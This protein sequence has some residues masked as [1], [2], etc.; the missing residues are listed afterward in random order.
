MGHLIGDG[1]AVNVTVPAGDYDHGDLYRIDGWSGF[2]I[3]DCDT[4]ATDRKRALEVAFNR[5]WNVKLPAGQNPA[6]GAL[7]SWAAVSGT[8]RGD[9]NLVALGTA[10]SSG[11]VVKV[12]A[13][14]NANGYAQ[15]MLVGQ[16][17]EA[18]A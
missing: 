17:S 5:I 12:V 4:A 9:T 11:P 2:L 8:Q 16:G 6:V 3:N 14:K 1:K 7:L 13:A 18:H 15:V 10:A